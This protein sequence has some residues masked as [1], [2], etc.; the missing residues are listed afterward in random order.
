[1][2]MLVSEMNPATVDPSRPAYGTVIEANLDRKKGISAT[3]LIKDGTLK[4]GDYVAAGG[5]ISPVRIMENHLGKQLKTATASSPVSI[6]GWDSVPVVGSEF[7]TF[8]SKKEA[9]IRSAEMKASQKTEKKNDTVQNGNQ[10]DSLVLPV[11]IKTDVTGSLDGIKHELAKIKHDKISLKIV[12]EGLG[13]VGENDVKL[14]SGDPKLIILAFGVKPDSKARSIIERSPTPIR[15]E[16]FDII[17]NLIEFVRKEL[18]SRVPKEY[19][20]EVTGR[21]KILA[22]FGA[23]KDKQIIGG[24]VQEGTIKIGAEVR[25]IRRD[26]E[27]ARGRLRELQQAKKRVEEVREGFEFGAMV[28]SKMTLAE[29]DK[30]ECFIVVEKK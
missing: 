7:E 30:I 11:I 17:Y 10:G 1:M 9:E 22:R 23:E 26:A 13:D 27:I 6:I 15:L 3:L 2:I 8:N 5:S 14:A 24:K 19:M 28:E 25:I 18:L 20:E 29:G 16:S 21:A 4:T 12:S